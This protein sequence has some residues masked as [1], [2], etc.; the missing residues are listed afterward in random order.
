[1]RVVKKTHLAKWYE[2][3]VMDNHSSWDRKECHIISLLL[4]RKTG[5]VPLPSLNMIYSK[6]CMLLQIQLPDHNPIRALWILETPVPLANIN[7]SSGHPHWD[8]IE[9]PVL[10]RHITPRRTCKE[11]RL[12]IWDVIY[13]TSQLTNGK[14]RELPGLK[15]QKEEN[16]QSNDKSGF[17]VIGQRFWTEGRFPSHTLR[18]FTLH[19]CS[20]S[21]NHYHTWAH[22][23]PL[24]AHQ[25]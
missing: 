18:W 12:R 7:K 1:M 17:M 5:V 21:K 3:V 4:A 16:Q 2:K 6:I 23:G 24:P 22:G 20:F 13:A 19:V 11:I 9:S 8:Q 15:W 25:E 14:Q 10:S